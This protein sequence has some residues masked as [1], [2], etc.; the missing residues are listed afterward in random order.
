MRNTEV[1]T[2]SI[3]MLSFNPRMKCQNEQTPFKIFIYCTIVK[4]QKQFAI[5]RDGSAFTKCVNNAKPKIQ[6]S[7]PT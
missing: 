1:D 2:V 4:K 7:E 3:V 6:E 5:D